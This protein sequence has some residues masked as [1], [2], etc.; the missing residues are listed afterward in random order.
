MSAIRATSHSRTARFPTR[1]NPQQ[2]L[3]FEELCR[4]AYETEEGA[5]LTF[6]SSFTLPGNAFGF[7]AHVVVVQ[8][9]PDTGEISFLKYAA[10]HDCGRIINPKLLEGQIHGALAQGP[11][12]RVDGGHSVRRKRA[13]PQQHFRGLLHAHG[14]GHAPADWPHHGN[15]L[16]HQSPRR[17]G[18]RRIAHGRR[19]GGRRQCLGRC[20]YQCR[21]RASR[22]PP[23]P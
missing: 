1:N 9:D 15:A 8:V 16:A 17:Q 22:C 4:A 14:V 18:W 6:N 19:A 5:D 12:P 2:S 11:W 7:G 21:S 10:V 20:S 23:D 13:T 3:A